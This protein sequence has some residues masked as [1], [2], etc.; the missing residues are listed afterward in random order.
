MVN[1][2]ILKLFELIKYE[3]NIIVK[4]QNN[5][6]I[7]TSRTEFDKINEIDT[8]KDSSQIL[9]SIFKNEP[10]FKKYYDPLSGAFILNDM[11]IRDKIKEFSLLLSFI[12]NHEPGE[13]VLQRYYS[14]YDDSHISIIHKNDFLA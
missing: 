8:N 7:L 2:E 3:E 1:K 9:Y 5:Q 14:G 11:D 6:V 10:Q 12:Q 4:N 13:F